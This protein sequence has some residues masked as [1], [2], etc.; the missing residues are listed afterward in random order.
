MIDTKLANLAF[1]EYDLFNVSISML[2]FKPKIFKYSYSAHYII[3]NIFVFV[4]GPEYD[5]EY[6]CIRIWLNKIFTTLWSL[7]RQ[8]N[9]SHSEHPDGHFVFLRFSMIKSKKTYLSKED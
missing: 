1:D 9:D 7:F 4:F 3:S 5:S 2:V 6:N 8:L